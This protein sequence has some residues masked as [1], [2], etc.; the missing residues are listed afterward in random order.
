MFSYL[1]ETTVFDAFRDSKVYMRP[2][3]EPFTEF[4]RIARNR[5]HEG[6]DK[7]YPKTTDGTTASIVQ[8]TPRRIIQQ[9]P[10]GKVKSDSEDWLTHVADFIYNNKILLN[11]NSQYSLI[12]KSWAAVSKALTY[13][14]QPAYVSFVRNGE[15]FGTDITL[16]YI[17]DVFLERGKLSDK[18]SNYILM[19]SW[20]QPADIKAIIEKEKDLAAK[21]KKRK[22]EYTPT[23]DIEALKEIQDNQS[24]KDDLSVTPNERAKNNRTGGV[25]IIHAFQKGVGAKFYSFHMGTQKIVRTR[26]NPDPRGVMPIHFLYADV[27][28][29]NPLGRGYV[30]LVGAMQNLIDTEVQM[31]QYNRALMLN[32]PL[33]KKGNWSKSQAKFAPNTIIDLGSDVNA[34][35]E[36]LR[37]DTSAI[38]Q[39]PANYGLMK[40]QLLNLLSSPDAS[41]SAEIGNPGFSKT[42]AGVKQQQG[43]VS[44]D[45]NYMRRNF[46]AWFQDIS[47]TMI[48]LYFAEKHGIEEI[49]VDE[50]TADKLNDAQPGSVSEDNKIRINWDT[51]TPNLEFRVDAST[52]MKKDDQEQITQLKELL[53]DTAASPYI[54]Y[55]IQAEGYELH[56]GEVY[57]QLFQ[58][59]G[60]QD[61]D[62]ILTKLPVDPQTGKPQQNNAMAPNFD[63]P[64]VT[65][66]YNDLP[67]AAQVEALKNA[68]INIQPQ[69]IMQPNATQQAD[70]Q[71]KAPVADNTHPAQKIM[72]SLNIKFTDLPEDSKQ[73]LLQMIGIPTT[74][75]TPQGNDQAIASQNAHL[76]AI[77][78][79]HQHVNAGVAQSQAQQAQDQS[80]QLAQQQVNTD[81]ETPQDKQSEPQGEPAPAQD[82]SLPSDNLTPEDHQLI[83]DLQQAGYNDQQIGQALA[84]QHHGYSEQ[85][86]I[87]MLGGK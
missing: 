69:D 75:M 66:N 9:L 43:N 29:S 27:D 57:K 60:L 1:D 21:A 31:Y 85:Q 86:I 6:I 74:Q 18:D 25:E 41:I 71:A 49:I 24:Q 51:E 28:M 56:T 77:D 4:E 8:K 54:P 30:E 82:Q 45:D 5:P 38:A 65:L 44:V 73:E 14:S 19:R 72:E 40:S 34:S 35:L 3:F 22:E 64:R 55:Y 79:A 37:I 81:A 62:K 53:A 48:N 47:E 26:V 2:L 80:A 20:Y 70:I 17:K 52:S 58:R 13:G 33:L 78:M 42:D 36:A 39:F 61:I 7:A 50:M 15:Y 12:Q 63:K 32:P 23:W 67:P 83:T 59:L 46:E 76:Q 87:Q 10:T 11:A 84:L 16:P 68:G